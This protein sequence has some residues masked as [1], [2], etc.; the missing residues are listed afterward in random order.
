[1]VRQ[2]DSVRTLTENRA[3]LFGGDSDSSVTDYDVALWLTA[4]ESA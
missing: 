1:M 2:P 3:M 4:C